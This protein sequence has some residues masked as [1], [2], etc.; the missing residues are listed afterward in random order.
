MEIQLDENNKDMKFALQ[1]EEMFRQYYL[2]GFPFFKVY[3]WLSY[4]NMTKSGKILDDRKDYFKRREISY[5]KLSGDGKEEFTIRHLCY[6][7]HKEFEKNA[8]NMNPIRIDIGPVCNIPPEVNKSNLADKKAIAEEREY[9]ID[10]DMNDY[11][12]IRTCCTGA[13][14]CQSCWNYIKAA[15]RVL[16]PSLEDDFGFEHILWVFSGRRGVHAWVCDERARIMDNIIRHGVTDYLSISI[17]N[18]KAD[19]MVKEAVLTDLD[20]KL[21]DRSFNILKPMFE[22]FMVQEQAYFW[23]DRN[24][25]KIFQIMTRIVSKDYPKNSQDEN[26]KALKQKVL[27]VSNGGIAGFPMSKDAPNRKVETKTS[28]NESAISY[29]RWDLIKKFFSKHGMGLSWTKFEREIVLGLM[30]PKLDAHVSAQTNHLLKCP[31][32]IHKGTGKVSVPLV[33]FDSFKM[34]DVPHVVDVVMDQKN[35]V[36]EPW[37]K[38]FDNFCKNL[39]EKE[40]KVRNQIDGAMEEEGINF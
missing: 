38:I 23:Y 15:Y 19:R 1:K 11:D 20:Y 37:M 33:D 31:F 28:K 36:L 8:R 6:N 24:I 3:K 21:F 7:N 39:Y 10:I 32:N 9:V 5:V 12:D 25:E 16:K 18:E 13:R 35:V 14:M 34:V 26:L 2:K 22:D 27:G 17:S 29:D 30:Y 4:A 40:V